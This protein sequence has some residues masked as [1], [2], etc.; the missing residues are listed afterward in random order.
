MY[1][2]HTAI[3]QLDVARVF[4]MTTTAPYCGDPAS[5]KRRHYV[6]DAHVYPVNLAAYWHHNLVFQVVVR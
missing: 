5:I 6:V 2:K 4:A 3:S 1:I